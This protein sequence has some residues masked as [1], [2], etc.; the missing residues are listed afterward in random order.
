MKNKS[1]EKQLQLNI[2]KW[3]KLQH[4]NLLFN[5]DLSGLKMTIGQAKQ[6]INLRNDKYHFPDM[7]IYHKNMLGNGLFIEFKKET[8]Y[9]KNGSLSKSEHIQNQNNTMNELREQ[10]FVCVFCWD[11]EQTKTIISD[12]LNELIF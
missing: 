9:L 11:F 12:Y 1:I 6:A 5:S 8:P 7:V 3:L 10:G 2:C 4:P